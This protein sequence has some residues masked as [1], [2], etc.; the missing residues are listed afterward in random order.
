[1]TNVEMCHDN[2]ISP[3]GSEGGRLPCLYCWF[4]ISQLGLCVCPPTLP[5][6]VYTRIKEHT[7]VSC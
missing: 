1:V 4:D 6:G 7:D 5:G 3:D 2:F